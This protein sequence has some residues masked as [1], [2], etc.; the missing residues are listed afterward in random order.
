MGIVWY[1]NESGDVNGMKICC[2]EWLGSAGRRRRWANGKKK[3]MGVTRIEMVTLSV[4]VSH[5]DGRCLLSLESVRKGSWILTPPPYL[6]IDRTQSIFELNKWLL[7]TYLKRGQYQWRQDRNERTSWQQEKMKHIY[8]LFF[9]GSCGFRQ[10]YELSDLYW[11]GR[12]R[13]IWNE[14]KGCEGEFGHCSIDFGESIGSSL[15]AWDN[16]HGSEISGPALGVR[17]FLNFLVEY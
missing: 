15:R 13:V 12:T 17:R 2:E 11:G 10:V 14:P 6:N 3:C 4:F 16:D 9:V 8:V 1:F 7:V 5:V